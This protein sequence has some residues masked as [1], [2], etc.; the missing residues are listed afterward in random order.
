M[1]SV[2]GLRSAHAKVGRIVLLGRVLDKIRLHARGA[3][4]ADYVV[5]LG[6]STPNRFDWRC[7]RF[8][9]LPYAGIRARTL[10]GGCDEEVLAWAESRGTRHSDEECV[11]WNRYITKIG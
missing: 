5:N 6:D 4:P 2:P 1:P 7:C 10:E 9:G 8:L 11:I 3:L